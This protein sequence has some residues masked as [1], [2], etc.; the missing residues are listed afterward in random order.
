M[1]E[2]GFGFGG[3]RRP[4]GPAAG[5][6]RSLRKGWG[7]AIL[8]P[9]SIQADNGAG[10]TRGI[11]GL[12]N[13]GQPRKPDDWGALRAWAWGAS[14]RPRLLRDRQ[15]GGRQAGRHRGAVALRQ[16]GD[17]R[18]WPTTSASPSASSARRGKAVPS[19]T[20]A[21]SASWSRTSPASVSTTGWRATYLKYAG[22]LTLGRPARGLARAGRAVRPRPVFISVGSR[23]RW[24]VAGSMRRAC[25][26]PAS[27]RGPVYKLLGKKDLGTTEFPAAGDRAD[28]RRD[29]LPP[30]QRR[31]H[32]RPELADV[33]EIRR[34]LLERLAP[35]T[36]CQGRQ[37]QEINSRFRDFL[38]RTE[39]G[40]SRREREALGGR[41]AFFSCSPL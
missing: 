28:R 20:A 18:R 7:Y 26:W 39:Q 24:K 9:N 17:R 11:I 31:P 38:R 14:R 19:C 10:L 16:G 40:V 25:S 33:S 3:G 15:G 34:P 30:A 12:C 23:R 2:F 29:R 36:R 8:T 6:S 1:M 32:D 4:G 5:S 13:K 27:R 22:P 37:R 35:R 21:T 41:L